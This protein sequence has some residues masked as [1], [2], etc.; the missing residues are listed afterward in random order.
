LDLFIGFDKSNPCEF[1]LL[2]HASLLI[3]NL[4]HLDFLPFE[5]ITFIGEIKKKKNSPPI[6]SL[7]RIVSTPDICH[8]DKDI[9]VKEVFPKELHKRVS[10]S[11]NYLVE[12]TPKD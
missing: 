1:I 3:F 4:W 8:K 5:S 2:A 9:L 10:H 11:S 6:S 7:K 12:S